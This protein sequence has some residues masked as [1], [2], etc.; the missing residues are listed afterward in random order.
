MYAGAP[1]VAQELFLWSYHMRTLTDVHVRRSQN[2]GDPKFKFFLKGCI[3]C[4]TVYWGLD[5]KCICILSEH[6]NDSMHMYTSLSEG[7]SET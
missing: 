3:Y 4:I 7:L 2:A 5:E 1:K 6:E